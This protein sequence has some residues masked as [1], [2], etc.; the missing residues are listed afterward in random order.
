M[1]SATISAQN[2]SSLDTLKRFYEAETAYLLSTEPDFAQVAATLDPEC[3]I[4]QPASLPYGGVWR[5]HVGL[6]PG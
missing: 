6:S 3:A 5:G 2:P 1:K 4:H